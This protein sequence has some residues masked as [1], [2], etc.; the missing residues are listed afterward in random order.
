MYGIQEAAEQVGISEGLLILWISTKRIVPS[1]ELSTAND[2]IFEKYPTLKN[3]AGKDG[4]LFGW[5]RYAFTDDDVKRLRRTAK[6][7]KEW[8][9]GTKEIKSYTTAD[10]AEEWNL[11]TDTIRKLF[12]AEPGVLK[13]GDSNPKH[14]RRYV[15]LRIPKAVAERVHRRLSS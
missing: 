11:S 4:E 13:I 12:E 3:Y 7:F 15:T 9:G 2:P 8:K 10:L 5:N 1:I 14:K 6:R